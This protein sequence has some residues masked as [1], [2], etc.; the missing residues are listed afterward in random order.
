MLEQLVGDIWD[1]TD[2][3]A[4]DMVER[5]DGSFELNG[6]MSIG[7]FMELLDLDEDS[8]E[9]ESSTVGGWAL[10]RFGTFLEA[11]EQTV[12]QNLT[13]TILKMDGLRVE[14]L[15]VTP[16]APAEDD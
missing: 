16:A 8:F 12:W 6:D 9:T 14:K 11:G 10:E 2:E 5:T 15:L 7:A 3:I 13:V 4:P 1:E